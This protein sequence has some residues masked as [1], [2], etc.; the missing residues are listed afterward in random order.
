MKAILNLVR[1]DQEIRGVIKELEAAWRANPEQRLGQLL[2]N[3]SREW[4]SGRASSD[5]I[6]ERRDEDWVVELR[7]TWGATPPLTPGSRNGNVPE[8]GPKGSSG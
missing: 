3:V 6:W 5:V 4:P 1:R 8:H 2:C 7:K